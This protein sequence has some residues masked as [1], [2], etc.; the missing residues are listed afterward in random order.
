MIEK[1][2]AILKAGEA[3]LRIDAAKAGVEAARAALEEA[4][5]ALDE[6]KAR[7]EAALA[8]CEETGV[9][10]AK[11]RKA[12]ESLNRI[13][14]DAGVIEAPE[15]AASS[16][17][18]PASP[19][20]PRRKRRAKEEKKSPEDVDKGAAA[21]GPE[22]AAGDSPSTSEAAPS[23][24]SRLD[25]A[26]EV[27]EIETLISEAV[28]SDG[29]EPEALE[30]SAGLL[31]SLLSA[32]AKAAAEG[33]RPAVVDFESF[34]AA[35]DP[36][37][38]RAL[39]EGDSGLAEALAA[40][41]SER[42]LEWF[43]GVIEAVENGKEFPRLAPAP[44]PEAQPPV[45]EASEDGAIA[46]PSPASVASDAVEVHDADY[47]DGGDLEEPSHDDF[48]PDLPDVDEG[49]E[50]DDSYLAEDDRSFPDDMPVEIPDD[51]EVVSDIGSINFLE[52]GSTDGGSANAQEAPAPSGSEAAPSPRPRGGFAPPSFLKPRP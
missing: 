35:L 47:P 19:A 50:M 5:A 3:A 1:Q 21:G 36:D 38:A 48:L 18:G 28:L 40:P 4:R 20:Q 32:F 10:K 52:D 2:A 24:P 37:S 27:Q 34:A 14:I 25:F 26:V 42:A 23:A 29:S 33:R 17:D 46:T 11:A 7:Y 13:W 22:P 51:V 43:R 49:Y 15:P 41:H 12:V 39:A 8:A 44:S 45:A 9:P 6:A 16:P 31:R 30:A